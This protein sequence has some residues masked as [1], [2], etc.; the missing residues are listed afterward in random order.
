MIVRDAL[1]ALAVAST[2]VVA[3][4]IVVW[5]AAISRSRRKIEDLRK[6]ALP[7]PRG[8]AGCGRHQVDNLAPAAE[9][10]LFILP[11]SQTC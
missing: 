2:I 9:V 5:A 6:A 3:V 11:S 7:W 1:L 8:A 10:G 4:H